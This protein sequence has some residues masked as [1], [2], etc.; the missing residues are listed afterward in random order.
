MDPHT[1]MILTGIGKGLVY[2]G[3]AAGIGYIKQETWETFNPHKFLKTLIIGAIVGG[4]TGS[5]TSITQASMLIG[6]EF[7]I[8]PVLVEGFI[9]TSIVAISDNI[10][11]II[12]RRTDLGGLWAKIKA[13][14][15]K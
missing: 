15:S 7:D 6:N 3:I 11:K 4:I 2:G 5:G 13:F 1:I 10:V 14:F 8:S 9:M 12:A